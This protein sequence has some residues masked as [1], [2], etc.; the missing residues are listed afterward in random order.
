[1]ELCFS[2]LFR[3]S[4][5]TAKG[6]LPEPKKPKSISSQTVSMSGASEGLIYPP[7]WNDYL[8]SMTCEVIDMKIE[9]SP[10][11]SFPSPRSTGRSISKNTL[12]PNSITQENRSGTSDRSIFKIL[13]ANQRGVREGTS[14]P[15]YDAR[16][17]SH[18]HQFLS[19]KHS[20]G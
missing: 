18:L 11:N 7:V 2:G 20:S 13:V 19:N 1:M 16:Q 5:E 10:S 3:T 17:K 8:P 9:D 4:G 6:P 15:L 14:C 12:G